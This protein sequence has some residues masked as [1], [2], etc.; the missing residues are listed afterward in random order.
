MVNPG[1]EE[2]LLRPCRFTFCPV[3]SGPIWF[4]SG[5]VNITMVGQAALWT[6]AQ[7]EA[8][9]GRRGAGPEP[10]GPGNRRRPGHSPGQ[11]A[12]PAGA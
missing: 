9:F 2:S 10:L 4:C 6:P 8:V 12:A 7:L 5:S 11:E 1:E 3:W